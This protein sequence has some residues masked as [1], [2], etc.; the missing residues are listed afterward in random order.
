MEFQNGY[1]EAL[2]RSAPVRGLVDG[3]AERVADKARSTAPV[4]DG[5]YKN[6]IKT[7]GKLQDRYV[8][9]VQATAPHSMV[10]EARTGNLARAVRGSGRGR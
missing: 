4:G 3:A 5:D 1:F 10:V 2:L 6:G 8:G 7:S 9:L